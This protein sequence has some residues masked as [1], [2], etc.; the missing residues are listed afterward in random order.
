MPL[1]D[2]ITFKYGDYEFSPR[3]L[4]TVNKE[5]LKTPSNTGLATKYSLTLNGTILPTGVDLDNHKGGLSTVLSDTQSLRDAFAKDFELLSL[6]CD[7]LAPIISGYP[8]VMNIDVSNAADNY[9]RQATY[10]IT[11]E[12]PTLIGSRSETVGLE[13]GKGNASS[14]GLVSMST[15][16]SIEFYNERVHS[17][18][19]DVFDVT[20]PSVFSITKNV[21]AQGDSLPATGAEIYIEPWERAQ[22]YVKDELGKTGDFSDYF[23]GV[24]CIDSLNITSTFRTFSVN[25]T[26]GSCAGTQTFIA[27]TGTHAAIEDFEGSVEKSSDTPFTSVS[28]NGTIQGF[29]NIEYGFCP[30]KDTTTNKFEYAM[31]KWKAVSGS[32]YK[33]ATGV[34]NSTTHHNI[35]TTDYPLHLIP[36]ST[37]IGYNPI[38]GTVTYSFSYNDR[39][40][41]IDPNAITEVISITENGR[42]DLYASITILGRGSNGPLLQGLGATGPYTRDVSIDCI[43]KPVRAAGSNSPKDW[44]NDDIIDESSSHYNELFQDPPNSFTTSDT[45]TWDAAAGHYTRS[46]S[47]EIGSC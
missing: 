4:F 6:S 12:M 23:S 5:I 7:G 8:K 20:L 15:D 46:K 18:N 16:T 17:T 41:F 38:A 14:L 3:P 39:L 33:R 37:S 47:W 32:L 29:D 45:A 19:A 11:L 25:H 36:L 26:D 22:S 30:P 21:S 27:Y 28:I 9:V 44:K 13:D 34:L 43:Y 31:N 2:G 35:R 1:G 40:D 24:M 10:T 42:P